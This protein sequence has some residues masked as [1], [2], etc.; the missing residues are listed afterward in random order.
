MSEYDV[1]WPQR[2]YTPSAYSLF[3]AYMAYLLLLEGS[4]TLVL[5]LLLLVVHAFG[6][7]ICVS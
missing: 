1:R 7:S 2:W 3:E 6:D 4:S 5:A